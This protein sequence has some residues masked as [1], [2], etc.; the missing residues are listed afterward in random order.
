[1]N[2]DMEQIIADGTKAWASVRDAVKWQRYMRGDEIPENEVYY[3]C[4]ECQHF[5]QYAE[6]QAIGACPHRMGAFS[7]NATVETCTNFKRKEQK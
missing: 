5:T 2:E 7:C 1:M 3:T 6:E 4:L